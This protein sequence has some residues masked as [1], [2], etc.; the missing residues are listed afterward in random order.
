MLLLPLVLLL[1]LFDVAVFLHVAVCLLFVVDCLLLHP[2]KP[3]VFVV[4]LV[5]VLVL[6]CHL[7]CTS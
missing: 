1:L 5:I 4:A 2:P 6:I 3:R 7:L